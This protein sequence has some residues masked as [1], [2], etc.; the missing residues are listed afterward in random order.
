MHLLVHGSYF[1]ILNSM[2]S[3][4]L[5]CWLNTVRTGA[6]VRVMYSTIM[7][8]AATIPGSRG[9]TISFSN[10]ILNGFVSS[11]HVIVVHIM[12]GCLT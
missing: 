3:G 5:C 2:P 8:L 6:V 4:S 10:L 1:I 9:G 11:N 12:H 7:L